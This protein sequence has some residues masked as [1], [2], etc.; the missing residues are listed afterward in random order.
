MELTVQDK[1]KILMHIKSKINLL[2]KE[3]Q[4]SSSFVIEKENN[5]ATLISTFQQEC[6]QFET[7]ITKCPTQCSKELKHE[8]YSLTNDIESIKAEV[9]R[10]TLETMRLESIRY[11]NDRDK[12]LTEALMKKMSE[13]EESIMK[14]KKYS[15]ELEEDVISMNLISSVDSDMDDNNVLNSLLES[16]KIEIASL[17][18][19]R[20]ECIKKKAWLDEVI[21]KQL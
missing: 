10:R 18:K 5:I 12:S 2:H 14:S 15:H 4:Q 7:D 8:I 11:Q 13:L 1:S 21:S 6:A 19:E 20:D 17:T 16:Y 3:L 9:N